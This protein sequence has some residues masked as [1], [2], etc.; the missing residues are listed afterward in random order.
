[1]LKFIHIVMKSFIDKLLR[2]YCAR[3]NETGF[4]N[5]IQYDATD[6][7]ELR[8]CRASLLPRTWLGLRLAIGLA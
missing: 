2:M 1:M 8:C 6:Y 4:I 5:F 3:L 7:G